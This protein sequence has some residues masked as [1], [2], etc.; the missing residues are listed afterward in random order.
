[1]QQQVQVLKQNTH[2]DS[3]AFNI[4]QCLDPGFCLSKRRSFTKTE[5][6]QTGF[7]NR[8]SGSLQSHTAAWQHMALHCNVKATEGIF[9]FAFLHCTDHT[10]AMKGGDQRLTFL[11]KS[12]T[13]HFFPIIKFHFSSL[14]AEIKG[15]NNWILSI[16]EHMKFLKAKF[17]LWHPWATWSSVL[18]IPE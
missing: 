5:I 6:C 14:K 15:M 8:N 17:S 9:G 16:P 12:V 2:A 13:N 4:L 18:T 7:S 11:A 1:M 10:A 3:K